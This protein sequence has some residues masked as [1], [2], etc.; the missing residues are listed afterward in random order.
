MANSKKTGAKASRKQKPA[1]VVSPSFGRAAKQD[2]VLGMAA[3][4]THTIK[5]SPS[6]WKQQSSKAKN[7]TATSKDSTSR[8]LRGQASKMYELDCL[9]APPSDTLNRAPSMQEIAKG[10]S[11]FLKPAAQHSLV[12]SRLSPERP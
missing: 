2:S 10:P 8:V 6:L 7:T 1:E 3:Q 11:E 9:G 12:R 4:E 5:Q